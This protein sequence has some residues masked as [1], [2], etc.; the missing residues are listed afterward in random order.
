MRWRGRGAAPEGWL[1]CTGRS[2]GTPAGSRPGCRRRVGHGGRRRPAESAVRR[3][4]SPNERSS[5]RYKMRETSRV[6]APVSLSH[7]A[8]AADRGVA[9]AS[10]SVEHGDPSR[11]RQANSTDLLPDNGT[12]SESHRPTS[13]VCFFHR[14]ASPLV[15]CSLPVLPAPSS[16]RLAASCVESAPRRSARCLR[17][18]NAPGLLHRYLARHRV[19]RTAVQRIFAT[20]LTITG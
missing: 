20:S 5:R 7:S 9:A 3:H 16:I 1:A 15:A 17:T 11:P 8:A 6:G 4:L 12:V 14:R 19:L 10:V 18:R 13:A 2:G